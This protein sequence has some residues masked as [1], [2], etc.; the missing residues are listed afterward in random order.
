VLHVQLTEAERQ[1]ALDYAGRAAIGGASQVRSREDRQASLHGD[2]AVG[3]L[4][5]LALSKYLGGTPLFYQLSRTMRDQR[6]H[7][8]DT[9]DDLLATNVDVKCSLMRAGLDPL[10][11]RLLVRPRERHEGAVYV[12]ALVAPDVWSTGDV[13]FVGWC[14]EQDLPAHPARDGPFAGAFVLPATALNPLP[15]LTFN[16]WWHYGSLTCRPT[17]STKTTS[18]P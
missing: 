4:G 5:E 13:S 14:R 1:L 15:P 3:Q 17:G 8:G 2:Q 18:T 11:Y 16:W 6:P 7:Q 9:G 10:R 12:L